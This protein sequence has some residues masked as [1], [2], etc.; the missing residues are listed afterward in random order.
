[1]LCEGLGID[2]WEVID[3]A[4][5]P[6]GMRFEPGPGWAVT[7]CPVDPFYLAFK[8]RELDF[9][10]EFD[11]LAGQDQSEPAT[12]VLQRIEHAL[13]KRWARRRRAR[14]SF[15][16]VSPIRRERRR[17]PRDA[18]AEDHPPAAHDAEL[19]YP[20]PRPG[21]GR[22][23]P[24]LARSRRGAGRCDIANCIVTAHGGIDYDEVVAKA[25][26]VLDFRGV[27]RGIKAENL[28]LI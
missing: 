19:S 10:T 20:I 12:V 21:A 24:A 5:K 25:P 26:L 27:T 15:S 1:M 3:A 28:L 4:T 14:G 9:Y 23:G 2:I 16:S 11:Q 8:A 22:D 18:G 6:F 13:V 7:A 17:H